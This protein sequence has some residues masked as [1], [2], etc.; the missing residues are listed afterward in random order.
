MGSRSFRRQSLHGAPRG[1]GHGK[2]GWSGSWLGRPWSQ[3]WWGSGREK[4]LMPVQLLTVG[5]N[6]ENEGWVLGEGRSR[7]TFNLRSTV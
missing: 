7:G 6:G 3:T 1:E 2:V 4:V 5:A